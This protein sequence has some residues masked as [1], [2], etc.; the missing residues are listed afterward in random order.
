MFFGCK[1]KPATPISIG[2]NFERFCKSD[3]KITLIK[4]TYQK[5]Q[6][7]LKILKKQIVK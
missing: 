2:L 4:V 5:S 3:A 7:L 6:K 1:V